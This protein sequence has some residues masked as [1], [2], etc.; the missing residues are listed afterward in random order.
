MFD[1]NFYLR[2]LFQ[3]DGYI[4]RWSYSE[5]KLL[6]SDDEEEDEPNGRV[7][8]K[9]TEPRRRS[10]RIAEREAKLKEKVEIPDGYS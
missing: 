6:D 4:I 8:R 10:L 5:K 1:E 7:K 9:R 2:F 3:W